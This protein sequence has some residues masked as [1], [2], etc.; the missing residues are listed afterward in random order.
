M[1][2]PTKK[3]LSYP[4][5]QQRPLMW[6]KIT[7]EG[8]ENQSGKMQYLQSAILDPKNNKDDAATIKAID[9]FWEEHRPAEK[10]KAKSLGY[11]LNDPLLDAEGEKQFDEDDHLVRDPDGKVI[12]TFKTGTTF[13]DGKAKVVKLF[14]SKNKVISLGDQIIGNE[15]EGI[16]S[17]TM[18]LYITKSKN[19]ITNA[20]VTLY[21]D[22]VQIKKFVAY[23]GA[24]AGFG[25]SED[26]DGF[27][28]V[29]DDG[30]GFT[31]EEQ[32]TVRL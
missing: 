4:K 7:G 29:D 14:N 31:G 24:D 1:A 12:L 2:M 26:E 27:T 20:G 15:S 30:E 13:P 11:Y 21:L 3:F 18:G 22:A 10:R 8:E 17:G 5:E 32:K 25:A 23:E 6:S 16:V 28:G 9:D 19:K